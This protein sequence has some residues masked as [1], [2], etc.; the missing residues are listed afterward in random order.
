M[1]LQ[2]SIIQF[3]AMIELTKTLFY[4][5]NKELQTVSTQFCFLSS[6]FLNIYL[7]I[8]RLNDIKIG[9]SYSNK[10]FIQVYKNTSNRIK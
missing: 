9:F 4:H 1:T 7:E 3:N 10:Y 6:L 2:F 8:Y 5:A